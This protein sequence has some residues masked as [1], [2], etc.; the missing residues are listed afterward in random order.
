MISVFIYCSINADVWNIF[1]LMFIITLFI[2]IG[3]KYWIMIELLIVKH[4]SLH[5]KALKN[6]I[7]VLKLSKET[8]HF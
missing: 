8:I 5:Y 1:V 4:C 7:R 3:G 6:S 2:R